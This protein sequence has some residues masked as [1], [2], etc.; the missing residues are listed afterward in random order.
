MGP[1]RNFRTCAKCGGKERFFYPGND[2]ENGP[3]E[4]QCVGKCKEEREAAYKRSVAEFESGARCAGCYCLK[5]VET[6]P[7]LCHGD[8]STPCPRYER[9][10]TEGQPCGRCY[11]DASAHTAEAM[12]NAMDAEPCEA[13]SKEKGNCPKCGWK[14]K[15]HDCPYC[16]TPTCDGTCEGAELAEEMAS[17]DSDMEFSASADENE[18]C[19]NPSCDAMDHK[20]GSACPWKSG[21]CRMCGRSDCSKSRPGC[22]GKDYDTRNKEP[23]GGWASVAVDGDDRRATSED[24]ANTIPGCTFCKRPHCDGGC[25]YDA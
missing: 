23:E 14:W 18:G 9:P 3:A 21:N 7:C 24:F 11:R 12:A 25:D 15:S 22:D 16:E 5:A 1:L 20:D 17:L 8:K 10:Q 2:P 19:R 13:K 4:W 6:C